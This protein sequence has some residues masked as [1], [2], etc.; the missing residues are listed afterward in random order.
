LIFTPFSFA[1]AATPL[2]HYAADYAAAITPF[3][4]ADISPFH[5]AIILPTLL[6][7]HAISP[8]ITLSAIDIIFR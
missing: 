8:L 3:G 5:Y 7:F 1:A 6:R 2:L 4:I